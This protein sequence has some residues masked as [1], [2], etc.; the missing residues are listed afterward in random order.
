M[1]SIG[2]AREP[3]ITHIGLSELFLNIDNSEFGKALT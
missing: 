3:I 2:T 1:S